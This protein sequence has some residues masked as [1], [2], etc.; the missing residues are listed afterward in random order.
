MWYDSREFS[1]TTFQLQGNTPSHRPASQ[2]SP[3]N[4]SSHRPYRGPRNSSSDGPSST[5]DTKTR[6]AHVATRNTFRH[7]FS[8]SNGRKHW[9]SGIRAVRPSAVYSQPW[10]WQRRLGDD[11]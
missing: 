1:T 5:S 3:P 2:N 9:A 8:R 4:D 10:Y 6:S 11:P 7:E